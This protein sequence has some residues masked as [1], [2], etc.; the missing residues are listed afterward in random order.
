MR[1]LLLGCLLILTTPVLAEP[2]DL[3]SADDHLDFYLKAVLS[4]DLATAR[5]CWRPADLAASDRLGITY[6]DQPLKIDGDS[7]IW[8]LLEP[9]RSGQVRYHMDPPV[10]HSD[11]WFAGSVQIP[12]VIQQGS[13][14]VQHD[15]LQVPSDG[16]FLLASPLQM[17]IEAGPQVEGRHITVY[18]RRP[19]A[20]GALP[21]FQVALLDSCLE[22]MAHR[23]GVPLPVDA[24]LGYL[25]T[26]PA[27][28][29]LLAGAPTVGVANLQTDVVVTHH[30]CHAHELAH[31][32]AGLWLEDLPL[33]TLPL[34]QE[35][36][37]VQLGGRWG[38]HPRVLD[39]LGRT[40]LID[41]WVSLD[42]LLT[43][44]GFQT[45]SADLTYPPAG[46]FV[47]F[48]LEE[49]GPDGLRRAYRA[50]SGTAFEVAGWNVAEVGARLG[51]ALGVSWEQVQERFEAWLAK[52]VDLMVMPGFT[53]SPLSASW[54]RQ[55]SRLEVVATYASLDVFNF[56]V[57]ASSGTPSGAILVGGGGPP[58]GPNAL[59]IE[60]FGQRHYGGETHGLLFSPG[61]VK[62]YDYRLQMLIALHAE[63]FWPSDTLVS[64]DGTELHFRVRG[65]REY[66]EPWNLVEW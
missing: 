61:E 60:H 11:G 44:A 65:W 28:V 66:E 26:D 1:Q 4:G 29:E 64:G 50:C 15:Y 12:V 52:P 34:L 30:P 24:R 31:L 51:E 19:G 14:E 8:R 36:L 47:G 25:L 37:A 13:Q 56:R 5:S 23:C 45:M 35:G 33:F 2:V 9:L 16:G 43:R 7:P 57:R 10:R 3:S 20:S 27:T 58:A 53:P 17:V 39:R 40:S 21:D 54:N 49:F 62:I 48:L 41:G 63:G 42:D 38:R 55:G 18:D 22:S 59:F 32:L 46:V 6:T